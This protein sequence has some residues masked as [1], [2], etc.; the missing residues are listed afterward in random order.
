[1]NADGTQQT[2]ITNNPAL[3]AM[4]AWAPDGTKIVFSSDRDGPLNIYVMNPEGSSQTRLTN[5]PTLNS[6]DIFPDWQPI[7]GPKRSDYKNAAKFCEADRT[8]LGS[9]AFA[10]K[11]GTNGNGANAYGKCVSQSH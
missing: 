3:D 8:F 9:H 5:R 2:R 11:Y 1:M 7:P 10:T 6:S 4:P